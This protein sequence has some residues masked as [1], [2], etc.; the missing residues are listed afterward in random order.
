MLYIGDLIKKIRLSKSMTQNNLAKGICS[1]KQISRVEKN[2]SSPTAYLLHE[3]ANRLGVEIFEYFPYAADPYA[4][5]LKTEFDILMYLYNHHYYQEA[6]LHI[7][8][9]EYINNSCSLYAN[10]EQAWFIGAIGLCIDVGIEIDG[11]YFMSILKNLYEFNNIEEL[12]SIDMTPLDYRVLDSYLNCCSK[13]TDINEII[14]LLCKA[15]YLHDI[16]CSYTKNTSYIKFVS[17]L[18]TVLVEEGYYKEARKISS[19]GIE[20]SLMSDSYH[21]MKELRMINRR[22][23]HALGNKC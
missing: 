10:A 1:V 2:Q 18:A 15:D 12:F 13:Q 23:L 4:Y 8:S 14:H 7:I 3:I 16:P 17:S 20:F 6:A 5:E 11:D 22:A 21:C 19:R 9:S